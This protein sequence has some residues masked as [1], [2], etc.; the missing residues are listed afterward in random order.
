MR[1]HAPAG[2]CVVGTFDCYTIIAIRS[3]AQNLRDSLGAAGMS[4]TKVVIGLRKT[5]AS[6]DEA[7]ACG[8]TEDN[9]TLGEVFDVVSGSDL[10]ILLTSDASQASC[11][12]L[13]SSASSLLVLGM[14]LRWH[15]S[16]RTAA[17][18]TRPLAT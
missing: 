16:W 15:Q 2:I 6:N 18:L 10:V 3:Q 14:L 8:F 1:V 13:A 9:G 5:S 4:D 7:R 11:T 17:V 12:S